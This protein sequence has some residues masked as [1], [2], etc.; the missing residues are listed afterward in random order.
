VIVDESHRLGG[1]TEQAARYKQGAVL[2]EAAP[3]LLRIEATPHQGK[4]DHFLRL[5]QLLDREAFPDED[6]ITRDR[7]RPFVIRTEK[8]EAIDAEG[9]PL[10][11]PRMTRLQAVTW[12]A[13]HPGRSPLAG[14]AH[15]LVARKRAPTCAM[16]ATRPWL[17]SSGISD[18]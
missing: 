2:A 3:Y 13:R 17:P 12:Q 6:S 7:V 5:I 4:T 9:R 10:F 1:S 14:E 11:K 15:A 8:R 16:A 18:S